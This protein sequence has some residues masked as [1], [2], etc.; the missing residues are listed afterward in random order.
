MRCSSVSSTRI[1]ESFIT[2]TIR[3]TEHVMSNI[4]HFQELKTIEKAKLIF[5]S[6]YIEVPTHIGK[7]LV[8]VQ[9]RQILSKN[10][11]LV[12]SLLLNTLSCPCLDPCGI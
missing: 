10:V 6:R 11:Y 5:A 2:V 9:E 3:A 8:Q 4:N 1:E 12:P 7:V